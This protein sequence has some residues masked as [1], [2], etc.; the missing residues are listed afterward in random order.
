[1]GVC[2]S[3]PVCADVKECVEARGQPQVSFLGCY[4]L[5]FSF[6]IILKHFLSIVCEYAHVSTSGKA[7][8]CK[9]EN[10]LQESLLSFKN[11]HLFNMHVRVSGCMCVHRVCLAPMEAS[12]EHWILEQVTGSWESQRGARSLGPLQELQ[13]L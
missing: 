1:M 2:M 12:M 13:G 4:P 3:I 6:L 10:S 11:G 8:M 5:V 9:S 7:H